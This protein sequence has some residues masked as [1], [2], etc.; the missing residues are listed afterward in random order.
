MRLRRYVGP[1]LPTVLRKIRRE[2]GNDAVIV[3]TRERVEGGILG[4]FGNRV[5]EVLAA[6]PPGASTGQ[7]RELDLSL[8]GELP[9]HEAVRENGETALPAEADSGW[10]SGRLAPRPGGEGRRM[11]DFVPLGIA[12]S[13]G[14]FPDRALFFGPPGAGKTSSLG[15]LAWHFGDRGRVLVVSVEE[16]GRLSGTSR[17]RAFWEVLGVDYLPVRGLK[18][19]REAGTEG[20]EALLVDTPPLRDGDVGR[21]EAV[22]RDMSLVPF[23]VVDATMDFE[24][25]RILLERC[26]KMEGLR[27]VV[28][29]TDTVSSAVRRSR[30]AEELRGVKAAYYSD[31]PSVN[32]P[33]RPLVMEFSAACDG[34][35]AMPSLERGEALRP[36]FSEAF[37]SG[38]RD[39]RGV[40][41]QRDAHHDIY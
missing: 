41:R 25:F 26:E 5:V 36:G 34:G 22:C 8:P 13:E 3:C 29:K 10:S 40:R 37:V 30:W 2:L 18:G 9:Q 17:W 35:E 32:F 33:L 31:N 28:C 23:L 16:E 4:F 19:L 7:G 27:V 38:D 24:E 20:C 14:G 6:A 39:T 21:L 11:R 12:C 15:R 1:D